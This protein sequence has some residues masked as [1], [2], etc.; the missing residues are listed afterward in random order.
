AGLMVE[1]GMTASIGVA[2]GFVAGA[3]MGALFIRQFFEGTPFGLDGASI[4]TALALVYS[5]VVLVTLGPAWRASRLPP[6]EA[7][8]HTE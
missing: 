2:V 8:R 5:A 3:I 4:G 6:A 7:V 1:A